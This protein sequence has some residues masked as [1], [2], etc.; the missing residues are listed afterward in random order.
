[1]KLNSLKPAFRA[2]KKRVGRGQGSGLGKTCGRG[3]KGQKSR[4]GGY[5]KVG[6]EGGQMPLQMR[7]PKAGFTSNKLFAEV[8]LHELSKVEGEIISLDSLKNSNLIAKNI[9]F[10]KLIFSGK[11]SHKELLNNSLSGKK[12]NINAE[13]KT[14]KLVKELI[15]SLGWQVLEEQSTKKNIKKQKSQQKKIGSENIS[16]KKDN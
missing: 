16:D 8:R 1:M 11:T 13:I 15:G 4:S 12:F 3:D 2:T 14:T 10:V 6:F 9:K 5:H 7:L